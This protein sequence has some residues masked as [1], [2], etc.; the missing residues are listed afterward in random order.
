MAHHFVHDALVEARRVQVGRLL[1][2]HELAVYVAR[3]HQEAQAE[4]GREHLRER[5]QVDGA[6]VPARQDRGRRRLI[7]PEVAIRVVFHDRHAGRLRSRHDGV[8]TGVG[9]LATRGVLEVRQQIEVAGARGALR[10]R[11]DRLG[12]RPVGIA[13]QV[14]ERRL[15]GHER[16]ERAE[17][18][19]RLDADRGARINQGLAHQ[20]EA[21]LRAGRDDHLVGRHTRAAGRE[22]GRHP[23]AQRREALA[24]RVLQGLLRMLA[25]HRVAGLA[26]RLDRKGLG[27]RQATGHGLHARPLG[28]LHNLAQDRRIHARRAAGQGPHTHGRVPQSND[29]RCPVMD[30]V[31]LVIASAECDHSISSLHA[32]WLRSAFTPLEAS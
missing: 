1:G 24:G 29:G 8:A 25:E 7:E 32:V 11:R 16:L 20:V 3:R 28:D 13:R 17:V 21:L 27:R 6:L 15:V 22:A 30:P 31:H 14:D 9:D 5:P 19:G 26:D 4:A 10:Q 2:G 12:Q 18:G 23:F